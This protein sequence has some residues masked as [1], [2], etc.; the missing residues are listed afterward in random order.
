M[1]DNNNK[2]LRNV[3]AVSFVHRFVR[4]AIEYHSF[5]EEERGGLLT[6]DG[7]GENT[8]VQLSNGG[9]HQQN[10]DTACLAVLTRLRQ[11]GF[12][13]QHQLICLAYGQDHYSEEIFY[14]LTEWCPESLIQTKISSGPQ[15]Y[16]PLLSAMDRT[17]RIV[18]HR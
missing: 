2:L 8:L 16:V 17:T 5:E 4:L 12:S 15:C 7:I 13:K 18:S 14:F 10:G 1:N 6:E 11:L 9:Y 3:K